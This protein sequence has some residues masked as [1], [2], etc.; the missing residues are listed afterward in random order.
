MITAGTSYGV[1]EGVRVVELV[2]I[3]EFGHNYWYHLLA[4]NEFEESWMDEGINTYTEI[5][6]MNDAYGPIGDSFDVFGLKIN[7]LQIQRGQY[8]NVADVDPMVRRAWDYY[9]G[10]SYGVNSYAKPGVVLTTLQ[11]YLGNEKCWRSCGPM[12]N[13]GASNIPKPRILSTWQMRWQVKI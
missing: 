6:I 3:H 9:S 5:Q 12:L 4:S 1:P 8:I 13:A 10:S 11:N 7:D 2:I